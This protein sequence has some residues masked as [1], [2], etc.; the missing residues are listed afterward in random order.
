MYERDKSYFFNRTILLG[1][2]ID[3]VQL[4][5]FRFE[6]FTEDGVVTNYDIEGTN[7]S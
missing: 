7:L 6:E 1:E 5:K 4:N 3:F 2:D